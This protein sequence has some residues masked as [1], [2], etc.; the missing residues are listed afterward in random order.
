VEGKGR[1]LTLREKAVWRL[2]ERVRI[3]AAMRRV[4][5]TLIHPVLDIIHVSCGGVAGAVLS[6]NVGF[7]SPSIPTPLHFQPIVGA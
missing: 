3:D 5:V 1:A 6:S 7:W 4:E 2:L